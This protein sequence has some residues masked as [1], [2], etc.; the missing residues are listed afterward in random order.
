M[1]RRAALLALLLAGCTTVGPDYRQPDVAIP[2]QYAEP[3]DAQGL[4]DAELASWWRQFGDPQLDSLVGGA[5]LV[6]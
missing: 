3:N 2:A 1:R 6:N 4:S 5:Q